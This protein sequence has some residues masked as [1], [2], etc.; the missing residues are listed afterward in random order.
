MPAEIWAITSLDH[1]TAKPLAP[2]QGPYR[3]EVGVA[4]G[5][6]GPGLPMVDL[7]IP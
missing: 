3:V 1:D 2:T 4:L 7:Q 6:T 5:R